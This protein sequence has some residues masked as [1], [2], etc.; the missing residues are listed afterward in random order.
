MIL[1]ILILFVAIASLNVWFFLRLM[2]YVNAEYRAVS[3]IASV[4]KIT[5]NV[6]IR[7]L[8]QTEWRALEYNTILGSGDVVFVGE[9]SSLTYNYTEDSMRVTVGANSMFEV[10]RSPGISSGM[11]RTFHATTTVGEDKAK[12]AEEISLLK[13]KLY[14]R[15]EIAPNSPQKKQESGGESPES[16][17]GSLKIERNA[18]IMRFIEPVSDVKIISADSAAEFDVRFEREGV[19]FVFFG[20]LWKKGGS[21]EPVWTGVGKDGSL[22]GVTIPEPGD[23]VFQ[24]MSEDDRFMS[25]LMNV[26]FQNPGKKSVSRIISEEFNASDFSG[27]RVLVLR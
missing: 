22:F 25:S 18:K 27:R 10:V 1:R 12:S 26:S 17:D 8:S 14:V 19:D 13:N 21:P 2:G 24:A 3:G 15:M 20:Y 23:Y 7:P 16:S 4:R 6:L 5:G 9:N 11:F